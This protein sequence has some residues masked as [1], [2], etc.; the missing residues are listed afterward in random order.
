M[1]LS[2]ILG[3][4]N[5][6][7]PFSNLPCSL[8]LAML[9]RHAYNCCRFPHIILLKALRPLGYATADFCK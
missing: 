3:Q 1:H 9:K 5:L 2:P 7:L 6:F 4:L 8:V